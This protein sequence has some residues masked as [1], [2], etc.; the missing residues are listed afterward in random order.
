MSKLKKR[1]E[2]LEQKTGC[3]DDVR[4]IVNWGRVGDP[5][6]EV[7]DDVQIITWESA[8]GEGVDDD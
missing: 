2:D 1:V 7:G 3:Q 4:I 8:T 5:M 6:P